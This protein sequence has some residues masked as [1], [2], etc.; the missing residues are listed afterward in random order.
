[1]RGA[2][3]T[4]AV[5]LCMCVTSTRSFAASKTEQIVSHVLAPAV[6]DRKHVED[7]GRELKS[8]FTS[9]PDDLEEVKSKYEAVRGDF[10]AFSRTVVTELRSNR[11]P[12]AAYNQALSAL[13]TSVEG[14]QQYA[15][16]KLGQKGGI[17]VLIPLA[18]E[19]IE[20][21]SR[22]YQQAKEKRQDAVLQEVTEELSLTKFEDL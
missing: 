15:A 21:L 6:E 5:I 13:D 20:A 12:S 2:R 17:A 7:V 8:F 14:F 16:S 4:F 19:G 10:S 11:L 22:A 3:L 9:K 18:I 1:M